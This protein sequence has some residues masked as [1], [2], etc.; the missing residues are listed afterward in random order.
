MHFWGFQNLQLVNHFLILK[1]IDTLQKPYFY[2]VFWKRTLHF[3]SKNGL[4]KKER[5]WE[6]RK[7]KKIKKDV[8]NLQ[9]R[10]K[11]KKALIWTKNH[12]TNPQNPYFCS[13]KM[14]PQKVD[15]LITLE[16]ATPY[17]Q[18]NNS[19]KGQ[20]VDKLIIITLQLFFYIHI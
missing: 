14:A 13:A 6:V 18:T 1:K 17:R 20:K 10:R 8:T 4:F 3:F 2:S 11:Q 7:M 12:H 9:K 16:V 15:R 19:R 5:F